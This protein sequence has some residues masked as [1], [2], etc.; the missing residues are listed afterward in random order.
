[1]RPS[2][3]NLPED[4]ALIVT[5]CWKEDPNDRPNFTQI[6]HMLL[7]YLSTIS[8]QQ[9]VIPARIFSSEN[10][11]F[12]PESPGTSSLMAA[13]DGSEEIPKTS[14]EGKPGGFFSC[15]NQCY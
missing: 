3:D 7:H 9:P 8:P 4:L 5:S 11:V 15:F 13:R 1:M 6:I 12:P 14:M 2:A 10:A